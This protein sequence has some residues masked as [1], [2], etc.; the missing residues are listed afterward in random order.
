MLERLWIKGNPSTLLGECKLVQSL[1]R[2]LW[3]LLKKL[4]LQLLQDAAIPLPGIYPEETLI[5]KD[6]ATPEF[7]AALFITT[8]AKPQKQPKCPSTDEWIKKMQCRHTHTLT[9]TPWN[10]TQP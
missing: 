3:R 4:K 7:I 2:P 9:H 5:Q 6:K 10:M 8:I 1:W